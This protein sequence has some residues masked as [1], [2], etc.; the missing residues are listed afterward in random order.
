MKNDIFLTLSQAAKESG[1]S[2][3]TIHK[4]IETG[5]LSYMEKTAAGYKIDPAEL[6]RVFPISSRQ[7]TENGEN[8]RL[9]TDENTQENAYLRRENELLRLQVER[10]REQADHWRQT[11]TMLLSHQPEPK[12]AAT[13]SRPET[14]QLWRRLF[15]R[16]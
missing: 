5:K 15:G 4:A 12:P 14:S 9:R 6:F 2:K 13:H 16:R 10:E 1:R 8:E 3:S 11:A 7:N